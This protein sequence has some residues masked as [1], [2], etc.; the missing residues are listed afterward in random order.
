MLPM[1]CDQLPCRNIERDERR[2]AE[3][4]GDDAEL[5]QEDRQIFARQR[6]LE[7]PRERVEDDDRDGD[8]GRGPGRDDVPKRDHATF[9]EIAIELRIANYGSL[10]EFVMPNRQSEL[11]RRNAA[12]SR[13]AR[14]RLAGA[15]ALDDAPEVVVADRLAVLAQRDDRVVHLRRARR[16]ERE[17]RAARS[18]AARRAAR[19]A[20]RARAARPVWP[21]SCGPHD[22]VGAR[23]LQHAVLVDAGLVRE[24]V[25]ADDGL[26][27]L[28]RLA[29]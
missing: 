8:V 17:A 3:I 15:H 25:A 26:V 10:S 29:R 4:R 12:E 11:R 24:G 13:H 19:S 23:V 18:G 9:Y 20:G 14:R 16:R 7:E 22:L 27:R 28:D 1:T 21:T 5:L 2:G 6:Q